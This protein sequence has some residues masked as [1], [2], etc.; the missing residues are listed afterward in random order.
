MRSHSYRMW[1]DFRSLRYFL[2]VAEARSFSKA[3]ELLFVAQPALSRQVRKL[4]DELEVKLFTRTPTGVELTDAGLLLF[5]RAQML[6]RQLSQA[7]D[8]VRA[9]GSAISGAI[10]VGV[11]PVTGELLIPSV[12]QRC[13]HEYPNIQLKVVEGIST[14]VFERLVNQEL[15][16]A[17]LNSPIQHSSLT[18][19]PVLIEPMYLIGPGV[20]RNGLPPASEDLRLEELPLILP[21]PTHRLRLLLER[22]LAEKGALLNLKMEVEGLVTT[23]A[24]VAAGLGYTLFLYGAVH[25]QVLDGRMSA[26]RLRHPEINWT[27]SLVYR[28]EQREMRPL[29]VIRDLLREEIHRLVDER[30]WPGDPQ[31]APPEM[32]LHV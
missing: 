29:A 19:E 32:G 24:L 30:K 8:D 9:K 13:L 23:K 21:G 26:A 18:I 31:Y 7:A 5:Q 22:A 3:A 1:M 25:Q 14:Y 28:T 16:L 10:T 27:L 6:L 17:L 15:S 4:E 11:P 2:C 20:Q 12:M